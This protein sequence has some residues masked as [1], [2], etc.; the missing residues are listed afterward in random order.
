MTGLAV[1]IRAINPFA[2]INRI[3]DD[4]RIQHGAGIAMTG[5]AILSVQGVDSLLRCDRMTG[6]AAG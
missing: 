2:G 3:S 5:G 6:G 4:R 1:D